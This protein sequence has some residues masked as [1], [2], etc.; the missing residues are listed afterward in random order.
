MHAPAWGTVYKPH[1]R[2]Q[3]WVLLTA[4]GLTLGKSCLSLS[5]F[6][7]GIGEVGGDSGPV[8]PKHPGDC[9][10]M[11]TSLEP[12]LKSTG[13]FSNFLACDVQQVTY[14]LCAFMTHSE[15]GVLKLQRV[16]VRIK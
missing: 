2:Q 16:L 3:A 10:S 15:I 7:K 13:W 5:I 9:G 1:R 4:L 8:C 6:V 11:Y 14:P 12:I